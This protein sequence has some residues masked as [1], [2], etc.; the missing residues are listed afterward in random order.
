MR[1][2]LL[3]TDFSQSSINAIFFALRLMRGT[4]CT[5]HLLSIY[6][7]WKYTS[8]DLMLS[9]SDNSVYDCLIQENSAKLQ[10]LIANM[11]KSFQ[12][13]AFRFEAINS[14]NVFTDAINQLIEL[15]RMDLIVMGT[16]GSSNI[17]EHIFG[18]HTLRVI[19]K[20]NAPLLVIP[21][22][23]KCKRPKH[24]LLSLD[25]DTNPEKVSFSSLQ[26]LI[27]NQSF[28]LDILKV[29]PP[30]PDPD[31]EAA[32]EQSVKQLF[33]IYNPKYHRVSGVPVHRAIQ[34][35]LKSSSID[36]HVLPVKKEDFLERVFGSQLSKIIYATTVPL[37]VLHEAEEENDKRPR[38][39]KK[40]SAQLL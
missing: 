20:V 19:R 9:C 6:K 27:G 21:N 29:S 32:Q 35:F 18:S 25:T 5:F 33:E 8:G 23:K 37:L 7:A 34:T 39:R 10:K 4:T 24:L 13:E 31:E 15:H 30:N 26:K 36:F 16:D 38:R 12:G 14:Y 17:A 28:S 40:S 11:E 2:I 3:P 22:G 1:N